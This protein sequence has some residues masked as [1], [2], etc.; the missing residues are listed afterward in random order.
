MDQASFPLDSLPAHNMQGAGCQYRETGVGEKSTQGS[1]CTASSTHGMWAGEMQASRGAG[2]GPEEAGWGWGSLGGGESSLA[3]AGPCTPLAFPLLVPGEEEQSSVGGVAILGPRPCQH[4]PF[5][6]W[7]G[8]PVEYGSNCAHKGVPEDLVRNHWCDHH[9][10]RS[11][12]A[13]VQWSSCP[14]LGFQVHS[15]HQ[16]LVA[17]FVF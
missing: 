3:C 9:L 4:W 2:G 14:T 12:R 15:T 6:L 1:L 16:L 7:V 8:E 13:K 10:C 5:R 11:F 17:P